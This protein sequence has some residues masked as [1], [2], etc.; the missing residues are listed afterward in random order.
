MISLAIGWLQSAAS[1]AALFDTVNLAVGPKGIPASGFR[2]T[3]RLKFEFALNKLA[4][5]HLPG[6]E[7]VMQKQRHDGIDIRTSLRKSVRDCPELSGQTE[8]G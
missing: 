3:L 5:A 8:P 1:R 7:I 2:N 4:L 6:F